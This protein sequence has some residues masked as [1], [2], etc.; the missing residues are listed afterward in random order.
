MMFA[1]ALPPPAVEAPAIALTE[2]IAIGSP[3]EQSVLVH[4]GG[5]RVAGGARRAEPGAYWTYAFVLPRGARVTLRFTA[6]GDPQVRVSRPDGK[7]VPTAEARAGAERTIRATAPADLPPSGALRYTFRAVGEPIAVQNLAIT[8]QA[9]DRDGDGL[10]D[11]VDQAMGVS[12][13]AR[14]DIV[15]R[16]ALPHTSFQ[17]GERFDAAIGVPTD[18]VLV[19][20]S[21]AEVYRTWAEQRY[22][23][24]TMGGFREGPEYVKEHPDEVQRDRNGNPLVIGGS[25]YYMVPTP[26]RNERSARY[27]LDAIAA[28]ST[29]ICPEE[30]ELFTSSGYEEPFKQEWQVRYGSPWEP[31][32]SSIAAR[33][34]SEQLKAFLTRRQIETILD[35]VRDRSPQVTRMVAVHSPITYYHWG[36][37]VPHAAL[38]SIPALQEVIGQVWT[39]TARTAARAAG[40]RAERTFEVG[41]LEYSS[42]EHLVRG[43]G[44][45]LWFLADPV[46]DNPNLPMEDYRTNY[47]LTLLASLMFPQVERYEVMPWPQ[48]IYGRVPAD[49]ATVINSVVGMLCDLWN[50]PGGNVE[51]GSEGIGTFV[52]DSMGWQRGDPDPSDMDGFYGLCLPLVM[53]GIPARVLSLDRAAE[54]GYLT[55]QKALLLS[56]DFLKPASPDADRALADWVKRGGSLVVFGGTDA[57]DAVPDSWW[58]KAGLASPVDDLFAQLGLATR[59][60]PAPAHAEPVTRWTELLRGDG[61]ER[62]LRNRKAYT[63]DLTPFARATGSVAVRF[64]DVSPNDGWGPYVVSVELRIDGKTAAAFTAGSDLETRFLADDG[65][66]QISGPAR[67]ADGSNYWIYRFDNLPKDKRI[68]LTVDMG[69]GFRV[70]AGP[71]TGAQSEM[72]AALPDVDPRLAHVRL[73]QRYTLTAYSPPPGAT[74]LYRLSDGTPLVWET[75]AGSG[76][77]IFAGIAP[78]FATATDQADRWLRWLARRALEA[79][80]AAYREA[81]AFVVRRGPCVGVRTL[82]AEQ[83]LE[84]RYVDLLDAN[85]PVVQNPTM[86]AHGCA[87]LLKVNSTRGAPHVLAVSGRIR[88]RFER[89]NATAFFVQAPSGTAGAAR[90]SSGGKAIASASGTTAW[91]RPVAVRATANGSTVLLRYPND[92]DGVAIRAEW[93]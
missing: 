44:K 20:S 37:P 59:R 19:Y 76:A 16:P 66:S 15:P 92:A 64:S 40:V 7:P 45:R 5:S 61:A 83:T 24:Q 93:R 29:A 12:R 17:T 14:P 39:G 41:Y 43:S 86:A 28:G 49:Y 6:E 91:G 80:G 60:G 11:T 10:P 9:P 71:A 63:V 34:R 32:H 68:T 90:L 85:L 69:N 62:N 55:G 50:S 33:Y 1:P 56:Y 82:S 54:P 72:T 77:V 87:L 88:A 53:H 70:E 67:F 27:Y 51:A 78:G 74:V 75:K 8:A 21:D 13:G 22:I 36:I 46:E 31:P 84:G 2:R 35:D 30:P 47:Q 23:L 18:A 26:S 79:T 42:L 73:Q 3:A 57:Y 52:A 65:G 48:R 4:N 58:R 89:P 25:S 81:G 38:L